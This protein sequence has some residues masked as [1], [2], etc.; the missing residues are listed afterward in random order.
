M[1]YEERKKIFD[2]IHALVQ[3]EQEEIFRI[4]RKLKVQYSENSNGVFFDLSM[5]SDDAFH[6]IKEYI[7]FCLTTRRD[8]ESRL[9]ELETIRI[10]NQHY[11][12]D[13]DS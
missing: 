5:I 12:E 6:Q 9:K 10:Q 1:S 3:P 4:I 2:T 13:V 7:D 8:H 11:Q